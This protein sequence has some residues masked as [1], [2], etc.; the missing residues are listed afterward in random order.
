[1]LT[2]ATQSNQQFGPQ[3]TTAVKFADPLAVKC[4]RCA[5]ESRH[6]SKD[7][8]ALTATCPACGSPLDEIGIRMGTKLDEA[9]A[10]GVWAEVLMGV[11]D[12]LGINYPGIPDG[13]ALGSKPLPELTLR[14]LVRLVAGYAPPGADTDETASRVVLECAGQVAGRKV[15]ASDMDRPLLEALQ[16]PHWADKHGR[17]RRCT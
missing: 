3:D 9:S 1:M 5:A 6:H 2:G 7:L 16:L 8:L 11:E 14:D 12:C 13:D 17:N 4:L 10:F 15:S